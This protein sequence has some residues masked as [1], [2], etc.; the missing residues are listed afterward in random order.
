MNRRFWTMAKTVCVFLGERDC[1]KAV[2]GAND[3]NAVVDGAFIGLQ[4]TIRADVKNILQRDCDEHGKNC[5]D[6]EEHVFFF[7]VAVKWVCVFFLLRE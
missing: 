5:E 2:G 3:V 4:E 1:D 6:D 7:G